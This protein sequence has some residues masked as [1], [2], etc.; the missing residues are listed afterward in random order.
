[1]KEIFKR[2]NYKRQNFIT[3]VQWT[4]DDDLPPV[5]ELLSASYWDGFLIVNHSRLLLAKT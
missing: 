3:V 4:V 2:K 5:F 1:M